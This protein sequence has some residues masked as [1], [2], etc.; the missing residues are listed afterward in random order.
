MNFVEIQL[1]IFY[2]LSSTTTF[3]LCGLFYHLNKGLF[4][5]LHNIF[6]LPDFWFFNVL[7]SQPNYNYSIK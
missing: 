5:Y 7:N 3:T 6:Y 1:Y 4:T 2:V